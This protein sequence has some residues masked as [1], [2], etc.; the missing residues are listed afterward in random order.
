MRLESIELDIFW[1]SD[2]HLLIYLSRGL[3]FVANRFFEGLLLKEEK[4]CRENHRWDSTNAKL[5]YPIRVDFVFELNSCFRSNHECR[6][7]R[8]FWVIYQ[9]HGAEGGDE[10]DAKQKEA[11]LFILG[12]NMFR[13]KCNTCTRPMFGQLVKFL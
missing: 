6:K 12:N 1:S 8:L 11:A 5:I 9:F 4:I 3:N 2:F 7:I 10:D 13:R